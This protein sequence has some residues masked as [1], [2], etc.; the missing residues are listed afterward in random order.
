MF[1]CFRKQAKLNIKD[2]SK[3]KEACNILIK[4]IKKQTIRSPQRYLGTT[5]AKKGT[6]IFLS[7]L[8]A[9]VALTQALLQYDWISMLTY[10]FTIV[11]GVIF[12]VIQMKNDEIY[13]TDEFYLY[14]K[15]IKEESNDNN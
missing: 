10:L 11:M 14:A 15:K 6:T 4:E 12:G 8:L 1:D 5:W 2:N 7:S 13:W 9:T 3:Y